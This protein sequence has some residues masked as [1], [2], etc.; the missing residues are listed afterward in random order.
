MSINILVF[1]EK[2]WI[3]FFF[4]GVNSV[5]V[6]KG[7]ENAD[8]VL[9]CRLSLRHNSEH[10]IRVC[11]W[12]IVATVPR[13]LWKDL[14]HTH[15]TCSH[16]SI[17]SARPDFPK[18]K[19]HHSAAGYWR[20]KSVPRRIPDNGIDSQINVSDQLNSLHFQFYTSPRSCYF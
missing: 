15:M 16:F 2:R 8:H 14:W 13:Y 6:Q 7:R 11:R 5:V 10:L 20:G 12:S 1:Q 18:P 4:G 19:F 9:C 3:L 17:S